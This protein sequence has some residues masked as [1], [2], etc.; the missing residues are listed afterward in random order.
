MNTDHPP[1]AAPPGD[2]LILV[3]DDEFDIAHTYSILFEHYGYRVLTAANG[4]EAL[5]VAA[6]HRPDI[7]LSDYMMPVVD[8]AE[9]CLR[10]RA[11][12]ALRA[13]PFILTSAGMLRDA[14]NIP[15]DCFF[16]KPVRFE[17]LLDEIKRLT[18]G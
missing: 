8:G 10:W 15:Y 14:S 3:V 6:L 2:K 7:V 18:A 13:I 4:E 17:V 16:K 9:L 5:A 11:D 12:P 1:I